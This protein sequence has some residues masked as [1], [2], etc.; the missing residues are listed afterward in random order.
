MN[1]DPASS[2][3]DWSALSLVL[4]VARAGSLTA[5][6]KRTGLSQPTL[7]RRLDALERRLGVTLFL[8]GR[9]GMVPTETGAIV[10]ARAEAMEGLADDLLRTLVGGAVEAAGDVRV[11][12]SRVVATYLLPPIVARLA[13][14]DPAIRLDIVATDD[15]ANLLRRDADIALRMVR[16]AQPD[17]IAR[18]LGTLPLAAYAAPGY[19]DRHGLPEPTAEGLLR[20]RLI[21]HDR[22]TLVLD[23]LR[24]AGVPADR[25]LFAARTDDQVLYARLVAAGV[26]IGFLARAVGAAEGL[27]EVPLGINPP[28]LPVWLAAHR[29]VRTSAAIRRVADA[30]G[31]G[32]EGRLHR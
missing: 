32:L 2:T 6:S 25:T 31:E 12:A 24:A 3:L 30:I 22:S 9:G 19:V 27:V 10:I 14:T 28:A 29:D 13:A 4:A 17:L 16:P 21:G 8:R 1:D 15:V 23:G 7:G 18:R 11:T 20:H 26:G 5:A